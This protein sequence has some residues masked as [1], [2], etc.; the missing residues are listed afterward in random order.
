LIAPLLP[1]KHDTLVVPSK[2]VANVAAGCD[3]VIPVLVVE[4]L[5]LSLT[6]TE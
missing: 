4:Q 5:L 3:T 2:V 1:P 6:V